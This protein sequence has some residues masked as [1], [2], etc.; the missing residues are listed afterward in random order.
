[1]E[2]QMKKID[3]IIPIYNGYDDLKKCLESLLLYTNLTMHRVILIDDKSSDSRISS[4]VKTY[5]EK[6]NNIV[7][8]FNEINQGFSANV[9]IGISYSERDVILLNSDTIVTKGWVDKIISC[10][11]SKDEIGTVTP[12][13]N[14]ATLCSVPVMC[15]DNKLPEGINVDEMGEIIE[16]HSLRRYPRITVAVGFCMYIKRE[17]I[18]K[19][20]QFDADTF[21]KGYGEENDF[22]N[23]AEQ[24]GYIHVMCDDT[25]I[26]HKGTASFNTE[27]KRRLC[28][29]HQNILIKRYPEQMR[30]N[31][32]Y[33]M[34]NP[35]QYIRDNLMPFIRL[36]N[37]KKNI[38]YFVHSDFR[39]EAGDNK[40]GT[41]FH[42][43]DLVMS[44]KSKYNIFVMARDG[45]FIYLTVYYGRKIEKFRFFVGMA[46]V[47]Q[48]F[49]DK[50]IE[51]VIENVINTFEISWVHVHHTHALSLDIYYVAKRHNIPLIATMHD[52]YY[53]CPTVKLL[54]LNGNF[55]Y[56]KCNDTEECKKC[57]AEQ[58]GRY[59]KE[60]VIYNWRKEH[61]KALSMCDIIIIPSNAAKKIV[62]RYFP[63][64]SEKFVV[65][66]HGEKLEYSHSI[67]QS[68]KLVEGASTKG[69][70]D[71]CMD[72]PNQ[73]NAISGWA[74][75]EGVDSSQVEIYLWFQ[76]SDGSSFF[77]KTEK[78]RRDDVAAHG[79]QYLLSG[80]IFPCVGVP[81]P[82]GK[83][84]VSILLKYDGKYF[85]TGIKKQFEYRSGK[86]EDKRLNVAFLGAGTREKGSGFIGQLVEDEE[87]KDIGFYMIGPVGDKKLEK[88]DKK[89]FVTVGTYNRSKIIQI[90]EDYCIDI[91][92]ILPIWAETFCYTLSEAVI[93]NIPVIGTDIGAVGERIRKLDCGWVVSTEDAVK[94]VKDILLKLLSSPQMLKNK[95]G[96]IADIQLKSLEMMASDYIKIYESTDCTKCKYDA[97]KSEAIFKAYRPAARS[98]KVN[99]ILNSLDVENYG[100]KA[101]I[102]RKIKSTRGYRVLR[103]V[104]RIFAEE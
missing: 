80:F 68:D 30:R 69:A 66:E 52:Y 2:E 91:I 53:I 22:C 48:Q 51:E 84:L 60:D 86:L 94:E 63:H 89:N 42:V 21:G 36:F 50:K 27:E 15:Q 35:D 45:K 78:N 74:Y 41:Q 39:D 81:V 92:C 93:C 12:L 101:R 23:R 44:L 5:Q 103:K 58:C 25:F 4:L 83:T 72:H 26:Y 59:E 90:M 46:G 97:S 20:G 87:L 102:K 1:M 8:I 13:S 55:C 100:L 10:A 38:L 32:Q 18:N 95:K 64:L 54:D 43:K 75:I 7:A 98:V 65:V 85:K 31:T 61:E 79:K 14:A 19:V 67:E 96:K 49:T 34:D 99:L 88:I 77:E 17:V 70:I 57:L 82:E 16:K 71:F 3:I 104:K 56:D 37:H 47:F 40:G 24:H 33:C 11:Y 9:N 28:E 73:I 29:E 76:C 6:S 62:E